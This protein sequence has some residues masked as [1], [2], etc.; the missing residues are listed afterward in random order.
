MIKQIYADY[1][2]NPRDIGRTLVVEGNGIVKINAGDIPSQLGGEVK[3]HLAHGGIVRV[4]AHGMPAVEM[5]E[6]GSQLTLQ[7]FPDGWRARMERPARQGPSD[8]WLAR[9]DAAAVEGKASGLAMAHEGRVV[10]EYGASDYNGPTNSVRKAI[11]ALLIGN[12]VGKGLVSLDTTM[13]EFGISDGAGG[14]QPPLTESEQT[15]TLRNLLW[16]DSGI[17]HPAGYETQGMI[18]NRPARG[19]RSPGEQHRYNNWDFNAAQFIYEQVTGRNWFEAI[20]EVLGEAC[21]F[22]DYDPS[23]GYRSHSPKKSVIP[24]LVPYIS[25][26]DRALIGELIRNMGAL[27]GVRVV[28]LQYMRDMWTPRHNTGSSGWGYCWNT[29]ELPSGANSSTK[30]PASCGWRSGTG[31]QRIYVFPHISSSFGT[32]WHKSFGG[33]R[34]DSGPLVDLVS[35]NTGEGSF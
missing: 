35:D 1:A 5:V 29:R 2:I 30:R 19:S 14:N 12:A 15:A 7:K 10:Y 26:H 31:G 33:D 24:G 4:T 17:Y 34:Y 32:T 28:P 11:N 3:I 21:I 18:D 9:L 13:A 27:N 16:S 8:A 22:R 6:Q 20:D 23:R 25:A